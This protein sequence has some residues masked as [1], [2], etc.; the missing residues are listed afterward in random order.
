MEIHRSAPATLAAPAGVCTGDIYLDELASPPAPARLRCC[1][2]HFAP[3]ART[4]WHSHPVGQSLVVIEGICLVQRRGG[5]GELLEAGSRVSFEPG[6]EHW[7]GAAPHRFMTHLT[8]HE[9]DADGVDAA[10]SELV[11][12]DEYDAAWREGSGK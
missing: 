8:M 5:P 12:D 10:W 1:S 6:E 2:C 3:G 4:A 11:D 7:H 9:L